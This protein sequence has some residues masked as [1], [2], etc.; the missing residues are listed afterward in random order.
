MWNLIKY[1]VV[2][3]GDSALYGVE[4]PL[5]YLLNTFN[6]F[7]FAVLLS[8]LAPLVRVSHFIVTAVRHF[9]TRTWRTGGIDLLACITSLVARWTAD[10]G[11][12]HV[13]M[14]GR[15]VRRPAQR[16]ALHVRHLSAAVPGCC[17]DAA[18]GP[19]VFRIRLGPA[20]SGALASA[21]PAGHK[22]R[23][24]RRTGD[25]HAGVCSCAWHVPHA[26]LLLSGMALLSFARTA[27]VIG[28]YDAPMRVYAQ[29]PPAPSP[30]PQ[31]LVCVGAE[32]YR[33]PSSFYLPGDGYRL[34]FIKTTFSG[35]LPVAFN[36][37]GGGTAHAPP[38]LNDRN[39]EV[40]EQYVHNPSKECT[41]WVGLKAE[42]PPAG[43]RWTEVAQ[44]P[45]LDAARSPALWRAFHVPGVSSCRNV[46]TMLH[47][48]RR[49]D[50]GMQ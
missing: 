13:L 38:S 45:F 41:F 32:W 4:G 29:L 43:A 25:R 1:N 46:Y 37:T 30:T 20:E 47:L 49:V 36:I 26:V 40:P 28:N 23:P 27:A 24:Y 16:G 7:N 10:R 12:L 34:G 31:Q 35:L 50:G 3:G 22:L 5:F 39:Q 18:C 42:Q 8:L 9:L 14:D 48:K 6:A 2:G 17:S 19:R 11:Q 44:A 33:F 15:D 21:G